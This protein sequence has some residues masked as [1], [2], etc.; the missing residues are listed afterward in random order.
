MRWV[1]R[2]QGDWRD[3][4]SLRSWHATSRVGR[5]HPSGRAEPS[6]QYWVLCARAQGVRR[7]ETRHGPAAL[8]NVS[9]PLP[10]PQPL[11][12][13]VVVGSMWSRTTNVKRVVFS[14]VA[15]RTPARTPVRK[16]REK[17]EP[18]SRSPASEPRVIGFGAE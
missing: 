1:R 9:E 18:H 3:L 7:S 11:S 13:G 8:G 15:G 14:R 6:E 16:S 2:G 5:L 4:A 17:P 10:T 12:F